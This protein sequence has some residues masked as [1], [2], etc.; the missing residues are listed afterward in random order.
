[1]EERAGNSAFRLK[2]IF[3]RFTVT[4]DQADALV[5][6]G[7][8]LLV[9][10]LVDSR[11]TITVAASLLRQAGATSVLPFALAAVA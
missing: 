7:P 3:S 4:P 6:A 1:M 5:E 10:D 11:W 9:D 8:V 2:Q